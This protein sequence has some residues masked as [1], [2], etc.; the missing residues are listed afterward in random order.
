MLPLKILWS[1]LLG[2]RMRHVAIK[3]RTEERLLMVVGLGNHGMGSTRHSVGMVAVN[4]LARRLNIA[5]QWKTD[6]Q[7]KADIVQTQI[8]GLQLVLLKPRQFMNINGHSV[9]KAAEK[10]NLTPE[11]IYLLHDE[12]DKPIGK[13]SLKL[14]GSARGHRGVRSCIECLQSD[15]MV[16]LLIG[17]GR[18]PDHSS[19]VRHVLEPFTRPEQEIL[20]QVLE[21][22]LD[23]LLAHIR[24][25]ASLASAESNVTIKNAGSNP[26]KS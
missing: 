5:D 15:I 12:L 1:L 18:P 21:Q 26:S 6:K 24:Q 9:A 2:R 13:V 20:P 11:Y 14:G 17:I 22:G 23:K 4:L 8:D 3:G 16:R 25:R 10:F 7:S 19:V